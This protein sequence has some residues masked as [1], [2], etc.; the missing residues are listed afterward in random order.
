MERVNFD[1]LEDPGRGQLLRADQS[2]FTG[3]AFE[4]SGSGE[5]VCEVSYV[6]GIREGIT[7]EYFPN[8]SVESQDAY[9]NGSKHGDCWRWDGAGRKRLREVYEHS[10]L[11]E[12]QE[13]DAQ[14]SLVRT[15][16]LAAD[17]PQFHTLELM[18]KAYGRP[19][20]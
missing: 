1:E 12:A 11:V 16:R 6:D 4:L 7:K 2:P 5:L 17:T 8:G 10:I 14:G 13:W 9:S 19:P 20:A 3:I 15:Y 18:R